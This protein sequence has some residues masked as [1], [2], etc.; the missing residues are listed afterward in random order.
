MRLL[1]D[2]N[3]IL[4]IREVHTLCKYCS[5]WPP[6]LQY[7]LGIDHSITKSLGVYKWKV[8]QKYVSRNCLEVTI[9]Y[10]FK[11]TT[12][13]ENGGVMYVLR[14][15]PSRADCESEIAGRTLKI[16]C[17]P[18]LFCGPL[19]VVCGVKN[20]TCSVRVP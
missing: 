20:L 12:R 17:M 15:R 3:T 8:R 5:I 7:I 11:P 16:M 19:L 13:K 10:H 6:Y 1:M 4:F 9:T 18:I 14:V 2:F